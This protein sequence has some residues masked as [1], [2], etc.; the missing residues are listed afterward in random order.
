MLSSWN[1]VVVVII[2]IIIKSI[3]IVVLYFSCHFLI[4]LFLAPDFDVEYFYS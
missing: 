3:F 4:R 2:I 1:I